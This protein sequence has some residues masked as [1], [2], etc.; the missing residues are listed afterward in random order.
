MHKFTVIG[1]T[2]AL[3]LAGTTGATAVASGSPTSSAPASA[4]GEVRI[5]NYISH[6]TSLQLIDV[7]APG[8]SVGDSIAETSTLRQDGRRI[9]RDLLDCV[10]VAF[11]P[12]T[13]PD[14]LCH[15][16]ELFDGGQVEFQG[17]TRFVTPFTVAVTGGT[18]AYQGVGG[19]LTAVRTLPNGIDD[20]VRLRLVFPGP[21][22]STAN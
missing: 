19:E 6:Q 21:R 13:G 16:A 4:S 3:L 2:M 7:G 22:H 11:D 17:E 9:G 10:F 14:V 18:G 8:N 5:L 20:V 12:A 1:A 15:G